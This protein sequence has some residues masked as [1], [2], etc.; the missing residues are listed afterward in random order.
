MRVL[1]VGAGPTGLTLSLALTQRRIAH[2]LVERAPAPSEHSKALG[3]QARTLEVIERL[4]VGNAV[5]AAAAAVE[6]AAMHLP[7]GDAL[8][9]FVAVHP[10]FPPV[11]I[12]PR[13]ET[14]RLLLASGAAPERGVE[15]VGL[16]GAAARLRHADG[17][18]ERAG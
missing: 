8:L 16:D 11:V 13:P 1:I 17:R 4:G 2:R 6:G 3:V 7:G 18:E 15:F 12:L 14:E 5:L 10:R 9:D